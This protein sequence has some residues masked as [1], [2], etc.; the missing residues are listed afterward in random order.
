MQNEL[1]LSTNIFLVRF[2]GSPRIEGPNGAL[3]GPASQ[4]HRLALLAVLSLAP[5]GLL[6]RDRLLGLL[7]PE[8]EMANA[9][10]LLNAAVHA[11]RKSLGEN[12]LLSEG[13]ALRLDT[14]ALR[15]DVVEFE[16]ALKHG[17]AARA[18][19]LHTGPFLDGLAL[20]DAVELEQWQEL[21]R[22][23]LER[24]YH[25]ALER[26][27]DG[28]VARGDLGEGVRLWRQRVAAT[29]TEGRVVVRLMQT[30]SQSGDRTGALQ[31][32][33]TYTKLLDEELGIAPDR[34]VLGFVAGLREQP[35]PSAVSPVPTAVVK[36]A[37]QA[38]AAVA[39]GQSPPDLPARIDPAWSTREEVLPAPR[40]FG[41]R[42]F[43]LTATALLVV[44]LFAGWML[45]QSQGEPP[46][47]PMV[48]SV[49]VLPF[50]DLSPGREH[51]H[52]AAGVAEGILN[53]LANVPGLNVP[54][55]SSSFQFRGEGVNLRDVAQR[56]HV[57]AVLEGSVQ[58]V[59]DRLRINAQLAHPRSGY[60]LFSKQYDGNA[61][62]V[63]ELQDQIARAI[64]AELQVHLAAGADPQLVKTATRNFNAYNL[65][66]RAQGAS[67]TL[68]NE[69]L[70][71]AVRYYEEAIRVDAAFAAAHAGLADAY[72][73]MADHGFVSS[74]FALPRALAAVGRALELDSAS[75]EAHTAMGHIKNEPASWAEAEQSFRR[76]IQL[77]PSYAAAH[78]WLGNNLL[79]RGRTTEGLRAFQR[80]SELDPLSPGIA[81]GLSQA[82]SI[83]GDLK[84]A[85]NTARH[86]TEMA[87]SYP[88][89]HTTLAAALSALGASEEAISEAG[90]AVELSGQHVNALATLA[91][92]KARRSDVSGARQILARLKGMQSDPGAPLAQALVHANLGE[93][94]LAFALL[95]AMPELNHAA[96]EWL[97]VNPIWEPL[98]G[99]SRWPA[100]LRR[101]GLEQ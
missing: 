100:L 54:A 90:K 13:E 69:G 29:P 99:H 89:G 17:D 91:V 68:S 9:R 38:P 41:A 74:D 30:L 98:R 61:S 85:V 28:A 20:P 24:L 16:S 83:S 15:I 14:S 21:E 58:L 50:V 63:F 67:K 47:M 56:L 51:E 64:I 80:A 62:Q 52:L 48:N 46:T 19:E 88:W 37:P 59:G 81:A 77:R 22:D 35:A 43:A 18:V 95:D 60:Q 1:A 65:Y 12:V 33:T 92:V 93:T 3:T 36:A 27:A 11:I 71:S 70:Q 32:S 84:A 94:D 82:Y 87:P 34:D 73:A 78:M 97:R 75:A 76:A 55:R 25:K 39:I 66:L 49:A 45:Q 57:E 44:A 26:L 40:R 10:Q 53:A 8:T 31:V 96:R 23:R 6:P 7:W 79:V 5:R 101:L 2:F 4:R 42:S 72:V 86:V